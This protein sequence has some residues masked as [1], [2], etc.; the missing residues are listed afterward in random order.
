MEKKYYLAIETMPRS[1]F[2]INLSDLKIADNFTTTKLEELDNFTL[3]FTKDEIIAA[4]KMANLLEIKN[5]MP[6]IIIYH[7]KNVVRKMEVLTKDISFDMWEYLK[8]TLDNKTIQNKIH[9]FLQNKISKETLDN[10]KNIK[11]YKEL[12]NII[13][14]MPYEVERKLYFYLYENK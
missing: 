12:I 1:Y 6:L 2:P 3:K 7:E 13:S 9:N 11:D 5:N 4:V 10:L 8:E 14:N